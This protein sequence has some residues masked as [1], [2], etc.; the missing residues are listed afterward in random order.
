MF[1]WTANHGAS[2]VE[3]VG[4]GFLAAGPFHARGSLPLFHRSLAAGGFCE[5]TG[6]RGRPGVRL[7]PLAEAPSRPKHTANQRCRRPPGGG[8]LKTA[9]RC[10]APLDSRPFDVVPSSRRPA[11]I[12]TARRWPSRARQVEDP[13]MSSKQVI[14]LRRIPAGGWPMPAQ[15]GVVKESGSPASLHRP[16]RQRRTPLLRGPHARATGEGCHSVPS[17]PTLPSLKSPLPVCCRSLTSLSLPS[18]R[19]SFSVAQ[20]PW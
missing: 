1:R 9:A 13:R 3:L 20:V 17:D 14:G 19:L 11:L 7:V 6:V 18:Y 5:W 4:D 16:H 15:G 10:P 2:Q 8:D 12:M